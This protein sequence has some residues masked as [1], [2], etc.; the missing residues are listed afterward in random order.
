MIVIVV[1][2]R[3]GADGSGKVEDALRAGPIDDVA[4]VHV[5]RRRRPHR[6]R[7]A[8]RKQKRRRVPGRHRRFVFRGDAASDAT[9]GLAQSLGFPN[10]RAL[11]HHRTQ[12]TA[13]TNTDRDTR[14]TH[15][16][17]RPCHRH[18]RPRR[19]TAVTRP[20][21]PQACPPPHRGMPVYAP[22]P[23]TTRRCWYAKKS[24]ASTTP[25]RSARAPPFAPCVR[26]LTTTWRETPIHG[27]LLRR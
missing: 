20:S 9:D 6:R 18:P 12:S 27:T 17:H 16:S 14:T 10:F 15:T 4:I 22:T 13:P 8:V 25:S 24:C 21:P 26:R 1:R 3:Q 7:L 11:S 19:P 23:A 5:A 2:R